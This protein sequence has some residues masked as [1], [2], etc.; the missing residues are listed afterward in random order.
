MERFDYYNPTRIINGKITQ[1][2]IGS[3]LIKDN[4]KSVLLVYGMNS[5]KKSGLLNEITSILNKN[6]IKVIEHPG[7]KSNPVLSHANSGVSLAKKHNVNAILAVGGGSVLDESK[8]IAAGAKADC[9]V[10]D[11]YTGRFV[12]DAL[13]L[14]SIL[15]LSATGSEM[16]STSVLTNESTHEKFYFK[17]PHIFPKVSIIN[18]ELTYNLPM[19]SFAYS[20]VDVIAHVV[21][22]Y[23]TAKTLPFIQKR[24]MENIIKTVIETTE[25]II[26]KPKDYEARAEFSLAATWALNNLTTLGPGK[27]SYPN[28]WIE[29]SLSAIYD[30]PHGAGLAVV[31]PAWMKW[32]IVENNEIFQRFAEQIFDYSSA[33]EGIMAL[34]R[35]FKK[36]GAP[37]TLE[38][39]RI[40]KKDLT[41]IAKNAFL[42]TSK[43][44][45]SEKYS[46]E[47]IK[48]ILCFA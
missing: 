42:T 46:I 38:E 32:S 5:I 23:F 37:T 27:Y 9:D 18:P 15:T 40:D 12:S 17:S 16:N 48:E 36:I 25:K 10:W 3:I 47:V 30:V 29:H 14:Y 44:G 35:W 21:E 20:A 4:I 11:F 34:E 41:V 33:E 6:N 19:D 7:V 31:L 28:H 1:K 26:K 13:P 8:A 39:L 43:E 22:V 24:F 2:E 45:M